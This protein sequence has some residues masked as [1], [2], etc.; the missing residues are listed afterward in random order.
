MKHWKRI[1]AL[2]F[3]ALV[4]ALASAQEKVTL[5]LDWV[6][7]G[8]H[9]I[10]YY[11][12]DRGIFKAEG[13]DLEV[14]EGRGS[15]VAAQTVANNSVMFGTADA[16]TVMGLIAQGLPVRIV[17]GYLRQSPMAIIFPKKNN[18]S[19][20]S[21]MANARLGYSPGGASALLLPPVLKAAGL[22]GKIRLINMEPAAKPTSLLE[23]KVDAIESFDFLQVPLFEANGLE[24]STLTYAQAGVNVPGLALITSREMIQRNPALVR[25]MVGLFQR[26]VDAARKDPDGAIDSLM[27]RSPTLNRAVSTRI[28]RLSFNLLEPEWAR[29]RPLGWLSPAEMEKS[30]EV[31]LQYG[32]IK[33]KQPMDVYYTNEFVPGG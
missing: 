25:R 22:E 19:K 15:A 9:A 14:L 12:I 33:T 28:L 13:I 18:W 2:A 11:G 16:G 26:T 24:V 20:F 8:Y 29:G 1:A 4:P 21:D 3:A 7:S 27:R 17:A 5:R 23:G 32:G 6:N 31:L 10:W 30:Q